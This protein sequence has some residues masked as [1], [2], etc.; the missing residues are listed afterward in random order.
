M[1]GRVMSLREIAMGLGPAWSL[2]FG[3]IGEQTSVPFA[4]GLLGTLC[5]A[6][7]ISLVFLLSK[8]RVS[9]L[10]PRDDCQGEPLDSLRTM[11]SVLR[12]IS[13]I[14]NKC[15]RSALSGPMGF[16]VR[17]FKKHREVC[18]RKSSL[19]IQIYITLLNSFT[20]F[21]HMTKNGSHYC[22]GDHLHKGESRSD[23]RFSP[24]ETSRF[25]NG[26]SPF[27]TWKV[28]EQSNPCIRFSNWRE[29]KLWTIFSNVKY[30]KV[31]FLSMLVQNRILTA[32]PLRTQRIY[33]FFGG[34]ISPNKNLIL[35]RNQRF[36]GLWPLGNA[37]AQFPQ[38]WGFGKKSGG[39]CS[40]LSL[41]SPLRNLTRPH[42]QHHA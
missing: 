39:R 16:T 30:R 8:V 36:L 24:V 31:I 6:V 35:Q 37:S 27:P 33:V 5:I 38:G 13:R 4:L 15:M 40:I 18:R 34:E 3:F 1:R 23:E 9:R 42:N 21:Q 17:V 41:I 28:L 2:I 10:W 20:Y 11:I 29:R 22:Y 12:I 7:S 26:I 19:W 32:E 14:S 25:K